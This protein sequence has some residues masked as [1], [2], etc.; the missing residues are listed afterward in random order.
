MIAYYRARY[1]QYNDPIKTNT[2]ER[3][4]TSDADKL[5]DN[6]GSEPFKFDLDRLLD[7]CK[8]A[9][10]TGENNP[11]PGVFNFNEN[12]YDTV[13]VPVFPRLPGSSLTCRMCVRELGPT[14]FQVFRL[15]Y[16][17]SDC[18]FWVKTQR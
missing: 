3:K 5:N 4:N 2:T 15:E 14:M 10:T 1:Y 13:L 9:N 6:S 8:A 17:L 18:L 7:D 12:N 16:Y 11:T